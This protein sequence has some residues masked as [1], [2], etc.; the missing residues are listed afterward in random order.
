M[1]QRLTRQQAR[2][3]LVLCMAYDLL[4]EL[5]REPEQ[6]VAFKTLEAEFLHQSREWRERLYLGAEA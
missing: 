6:K 3:F 4:R 5:V 1:G 2:E